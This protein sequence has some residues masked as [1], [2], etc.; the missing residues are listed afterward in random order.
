MKD[1]FY[2]SPHQRGQTGELLSNLAS[3]C[4]RFDLVGV[5]IKMFLNCLHL[6]R[7]WKMPQKYNPFSLR[8]LEDEAH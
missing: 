4:I 8:K 7:N 2:T 5:V 6:S 3:R 1:I